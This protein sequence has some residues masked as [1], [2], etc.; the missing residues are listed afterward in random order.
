MNHSVTRYFDG[1]AIEHYDVDE[2]KSRRKNLV[3][4]LRN[5]KPHIKDYIKIELEYLDRLIS[6]CE[7]EKQ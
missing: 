3:Y 6:R 2:L 5:A 1:T 4:Q 7:K